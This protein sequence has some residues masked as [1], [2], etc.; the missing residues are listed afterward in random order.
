[1]FGVEGSVNRSYMLKSAPQS[2]GPTDEDV[3]TMR[4]GVELHHMKTQSLNQLNH[5]KPFVWAKRN[6]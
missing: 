4:N 1:M 6:S 5:A 2:R 3:A